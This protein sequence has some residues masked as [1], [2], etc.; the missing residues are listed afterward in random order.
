MMEEGWKVANGKS[1]AKLDD[2]S[3]NKIN[4]DRTQERNPRRQKHKDEEAGGGT[5]MRRVGMRCSRVLLY[6]IRCPACNSANN[7]HSR[8]HRVWEAAL[9]F[10]RGAGM[11]EWII[12]CMAEATFHHPR[13]RTNSQRKGIQR[14]G[15][16]NDA[17]M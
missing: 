16:A 9:G 13:I 6:M 14:R 1:I 7:N 8:G 3:G 11:V 2:S 17:A 5:V 4:G 10:S 15:G 12:I